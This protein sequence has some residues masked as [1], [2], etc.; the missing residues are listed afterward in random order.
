VFLG[1][2]LLALGLSR[3]SLTGSGDTDGSMRR[4]AVGVG[5]GFEQVDA[6][7]RRWPTAGLALLTLAGAFAWLMFGPVR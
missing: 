2:T 7:L 3:R 4:A 6:F 1:G 5:R